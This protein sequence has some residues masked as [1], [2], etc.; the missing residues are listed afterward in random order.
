MKLR[1]RRLIKINILHRIIS[2]HLWI[3]GAGSLFFKLKWIIFVNPIE[4]LV[5]TYKEIS[6]P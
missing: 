6:A 1:F 5:L 3:F 4:L 2:V